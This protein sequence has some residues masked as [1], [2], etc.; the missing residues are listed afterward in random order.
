MAFLL[1]I[2]GSKSDHEPKDGGRFTREEIEVF[3][4]GRGELTY[5]RYPWPN[6]PTFTAMAYH[7]KDSTEPVNQGM[8]KYLGGFS[9]FRGKV[10]LLSAFDAPLPDGQDA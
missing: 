3:I 10:L 7:R 6:G 9:S 2:D 4:P 1:H 8:T 5:R